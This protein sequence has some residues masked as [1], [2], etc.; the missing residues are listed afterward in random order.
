MERPRSGHDLVFWECHPDE[1]VQKTTVVFGSSDHS[2]VSQV[3][4]ETKK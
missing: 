4:L 1:D 2:G 3:V